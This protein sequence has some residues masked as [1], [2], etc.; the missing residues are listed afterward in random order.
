MRR[1]AAIAG[2]AGVLLLATGT[3]A[4]DAATRAAPPD[5]RPGLTT[6]SVDRY[7]RDYIRR[8]DLPGALVTVVKGDRV[9]YAAGHGHTAGGEAITADTPMPLASLSKSFTALAVL[10]LADEGRIDLDV[11]VRRYLPE[12]TMADPRAEKITVRQLLQQTSGMS[13]RTFPELTLPA[14]D[15][16]K[17]AVAMLGTAPLAAAPGTRMIYHNPNYAVAARLAEVVSG[18]PFADLMAA[19]VFTPLGMTSTRTVDTTEE[20]PGAGAG[21]IRAYG[22]VIERAHPKWFVNGSYGV[23]STAHDLAEWLITQN[24]H[25]DALPR[26]LVKATQTPSGVGGSTYGMGWSAERTAGGAPMLRHTGWLLTH[27]SAQTLLPAGGYGI[28]VVTNTG[29]ISGDDALIISDGLVDMI[30]GR[31]A[32]GAMPFTTK[33]DPWLGGMSLLTLGLG[34]AGVLRSRR[35]AR[36]RAHRPAWRVI[37]RLVPYAL[38]VAFYFGLAELAGVLLNRVGTLDQLTYVWLALYVWA[39]TGALAAMAVV[40]A[41]LVHAVRSRRRTVDSV[42]A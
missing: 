42:P 33:A 32:A 11:P 1:I 2:L 18:T 20:L 39:A 37:A 4:V 24:G 10:R 6:E 9:V 3:A 30:E 12:F 22:R 29:M 38:P 17:G 36:R 21:Y 15:D 27:N 26:G 23:V 35:W 16:L 5:G 31:P 34:V 14:P 8:T 25:G 7:V 13:D 41:R 40:A 28:A 19:T